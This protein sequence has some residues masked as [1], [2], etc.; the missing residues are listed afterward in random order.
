MDMIFNHTQE[1]L[2]GE[3]A[4][5]IV[6]SIFGLLS[7]IT[8]MVLW[9]MATSHAGRS[10]VFPLLLCGIVYTG[11]GFNM[12]SVNKGRVEEYRSR[13]EKNPTEFV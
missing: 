13:Y 9:L 5:G 2:N 11:I 4:E 3:W 8:A 12:L 7:I 10:L 6:V 1:W